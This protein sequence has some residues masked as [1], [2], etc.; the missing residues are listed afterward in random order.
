MCLLKRFWD[1]SRAIVVSTLGSL[2][3]SQCLGIEKWDETGQYVLS[4]D[5]FMQNFRI[6]VC[7]LRNIRNHVLLLF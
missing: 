2:E 1:K 6:L 3:F 4:Y 7:Y 5:I